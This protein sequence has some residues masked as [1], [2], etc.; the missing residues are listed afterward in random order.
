MEFMPV[1]VNQGETESEITDNTTTSNDSTSNS[2]SSTV[3]RYTHTMKGDNGVVVTNQ[4]LVREFREL[5]V[6]FNE[7][8][9]DE[10][11]TLFMGLY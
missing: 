3:E 1:G 11:N 4:Y 5:A 9:I 10:L 6:S 2:N 8:I 7:Q